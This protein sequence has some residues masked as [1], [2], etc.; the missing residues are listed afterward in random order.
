MCADAFWRGSLAIVSLLISSCTASPADELAADPAT[1][2]M[3]M[4]A[5]ENEG[6]VDVIEDAPYRIEGLFDRLDQNRVW[7][8]SSEGNDFAEVGDPSEFSRFKDGDPIAFACYDAGLVEVGTNSYTRRATQY[9][10]CSLVE[11]EGTSDTPTSD[12]SNLADLKDQVDLEESL[13]GMA[14]Q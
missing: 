2:E 6:S 5:L 8:F 14:D 9:S 12:Y 4:T 3:N 11:S 10:G 1:T 13:R 7:I